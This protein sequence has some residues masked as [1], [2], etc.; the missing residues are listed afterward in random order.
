MS[1]LS[2]FAPSTRQLATAL[3]PAA[4]VNPRPTR[5]LR[6]TLYSSVLTVIVA[7]QVAAFAQ[8][9]NQKQNESQGQK[10]EAPKPFIEPAEMR[11][12]KWVCGHS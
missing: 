2:F 6:T 11:H 3:K 7:M 4:A 1:A 10:T 12:E 5:W 9:D 8:S